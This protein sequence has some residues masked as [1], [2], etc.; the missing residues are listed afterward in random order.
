MEQTKR[1]YALSADDNI[2]FLCDL[3]HHSAQYS[4]LFDHPYLAMYKRLHETY[5]TAVRLNLFAENDERY[6]ERY[7]T[8]AL[9]NMTERYRDEF[10]AN[11]HWLRFAFH[12]K[13]E[14][15]A[16]PYEFSTGEDIAEDC[17]RVHNEVR[18]FA[19]EECL[20]TATTIHF[21]T[22]N[23]AGTKALYA[24]GV[25]VLM[26]FTESSSATD[27]RYYLTDEQVQEVKKYGVWKDAETD[28]AFGVIA[29]VLNCQSADASQ[30]IL[31][32]FR[33][34]YPYCRHLEL[35]I[36]EQYFYEHYGAYLPDFEERV[37]AGCRWCTEN[38]YAPVFSGDVLGK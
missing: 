5:G 11:A 10:R 24:E 21:G 20:E 30:K 22:A 26:G 2:W 37:S 6:T 7:G 8:F 32:N 34:K 23:L 29:C 19:G 12:S 36:H 31:E 28:M 18:R 3:T 27:V 25:R 38:G 1:T 17:R 16:R 15:P 4:S 14:F 9:E 13:T 35:M 33:Q